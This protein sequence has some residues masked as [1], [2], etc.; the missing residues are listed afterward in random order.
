MKLFG[1]LLLILALLEFCLAVTVSNSGKRI[2]PYKKYSYNG[3][4]AKR[5]FPFR[6]QD[7][8]NDADDGSSS[9]SSDDSS[10]TDGDSKSK[11]LRIPQINFYSSIPNALGTV[12]Q[13]FLWIR[14]FS[15]AIGS[16]LPI[17]I[18]TIPMLLLGIG[19]I[20]IPDLTQLG[21][22]F[23]LVYPGGDSDSLP[24]LSDLAD[25]AN[26]DFLKQAGQLLPPGILTKRG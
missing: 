3:V 22:P 15:A 21:L 20:F 25:L 7:D 2:D 18:L 1:I 16:P 17:F 9:S 12:G 4:S 6:R 8:D 19:L 26:L 5:T 14:E 23:P 10:S 24:T 13:G 11:N